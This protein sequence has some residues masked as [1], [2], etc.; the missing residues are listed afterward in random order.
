MDC[1]LKGNRLIFKNGDV[2][3]VDGEREVGK[4]TDTALFE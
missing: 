2:F 4:P 3:T 1:F